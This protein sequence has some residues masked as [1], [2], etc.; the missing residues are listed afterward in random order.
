ME[1]I[2]KNNIKTVLSIEYRVSSQERKQK[3]KIQDS[4]E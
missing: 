3:R 2:Y 1:N 4:I